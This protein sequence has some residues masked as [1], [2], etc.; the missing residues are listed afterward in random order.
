MEPLS[1]REVLRA[2]AAFGGAAL[3]GAAAGRG[4]AVAAVAATSG[5][6]AADWRALAA[7]LD[8]ELVRRHHAAYDQLKLLFNT[9]YDSTRPLAIVEAASPADVSE[10]IGFAR[11][12]GLRARP[13]SGGHSYV[14]ASTANEG[15][16]ID[17]RRMQSI[18]YDSA[19]GVATVGAGA[20]TYSIHAALAHHGRTIPTGTCPTVGVAGLTL[21]GGVGIDS[22]RYGLSC[23]ALTGLTMVTADGKVRSAGEGQ[24]SDLYWASQGGGGGNFAI[25][26][27]LRYSTHAAEPM[28]TFSLRFDWQHAVS[29]VRGWAA[30]IEVMPRSVWSNMRLEIGAD[31]ST[32]VRLGGC[33]A[34][35]DQ[36][37][38]ALAFQRAIGVDAISVSTSQKSFIQA[39]NYFGGGST[40]ARRATVSGS[41]VVAN[42]TETLAEALPRLLEQ[43]AS[44]GTT[45][46]LILDPLNGAITDRTAAATPFPWRHHLAELHWYVQFPSDPTK[47]AVSA[48]RDWINSAH[49]AIAPQSAGAYINR[50]EPGRHLAAYY[51]A[52]LD[53]LRRIKAAVDP[54]GFF[55]SPY[56]V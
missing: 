50:L 10:G 34:P 20:Q 26:T 18:T 12:F 41:D 14:G 30:R 33:C 54:T 2:A 31:G 48:A 47:D 22:R 35:G 25:A 53:R 52:N 37:G 23:D 5:P 15:V 19:S 6:T 7:S 29:V 17:V 24:E 51:G 44:T 32:R 16:V 4:R 36:D 38:E 1:R 8:G 3:A 9:R 40:T 42:M 13:R 49:Q 56:T 55:R 27:S 28:G 45:S 46:S 21:G 39:V 43:R 11:R